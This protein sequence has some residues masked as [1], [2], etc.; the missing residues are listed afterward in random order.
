MTHRRHAAHRVAEYIPESVVEAPHY[1]FI[2]LVIVALAV[3]SLVVL[4]AALLA[5]GANAQTRSPAPAVRATLEARHGSGIAGSVSVTPHGTASL[6]TVTM[7][8]PV[9]RRSRA[10]TLMDGRD[11]SDAVRRD[12]TVATLNPVAGR[13]SRTV[14]AIPFRAF[15]SRSFVVDVR[16]ATASAQRNEACGRL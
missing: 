9:D 3:T 13:V 4:L 7:R 12:V 1:R 2:G 15:S 14:V 5:T 10:L 16:D 11:C 6:V 8:S